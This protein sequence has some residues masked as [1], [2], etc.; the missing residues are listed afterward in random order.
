M[1]KNVTP[2]MGTVK[3]GP[4]GQI[5]IPKEVRNMFGIE[6]GDSLIIMAHPERGIGIERPSTLTKI[7][8][9]IFA[10]HGRDI[11]KAEPDENLQYFAT[12]IKNT[13]DGGEEK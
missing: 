4:K 8:N 5:V 9:A 1:N 13:L 11:Y 6:S 10:G 12:N 3:V 2:Y 7:A